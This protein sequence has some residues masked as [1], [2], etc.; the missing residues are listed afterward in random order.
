MKLYILT[1]TAIAGFFTMMSY[2][3]PKPSPAPIPAATA[4]K[5]AKA[6]TCDCADICKKVPKEEQCGI[7]LCNGKMGR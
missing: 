3:R 1:W 4:S 5:S 6:S 2:D 7:E